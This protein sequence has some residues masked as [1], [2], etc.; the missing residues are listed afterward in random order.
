MGDDIKAN[1][2][3]ILPMSF[4][5][6]SFDIL[7]LFQNEGVQTPS[8]FNVVPPPVVVKLERAVALIAVVDVCQIS[9][10]ISIATHTE[11]RQQISIGIDLKRDPQDANLERVQCSSRSHI[12][13]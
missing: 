2:L 8:V 3:K 11:G 10:F 13:S 12:I 5:S 9:F 6:F 4:A 7:L 1:R